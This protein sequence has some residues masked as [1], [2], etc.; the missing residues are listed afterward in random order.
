MEF[1]VLEPIGKNS[2]TSI[3]RCG[4]PGLGQHTLI[5][6]KYFNI[7]KM[8]RSGPTNHSMSANKF[9]AARLAEAKRRAKI[10][11]RN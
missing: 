8:G 11:R 4:T 7:V 2:T 10:R 3:P 9:A 1:I 6:L 5:K